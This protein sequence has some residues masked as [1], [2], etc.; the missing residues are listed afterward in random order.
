VVGAVVGVA[1][2]SGKN[3]SQIFCNRSTV[4]LAAASWLATSITYSGSGLIVVY[5]SNAPIIAQR[6]RPVYLKIALLLDLPEAYNVSDEYQM[7]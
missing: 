6:V 5:N 3:P 7:G 4:D 2:S 1:T